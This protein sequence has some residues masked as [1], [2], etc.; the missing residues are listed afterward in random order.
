[1]I[2]LENLSK[3]LLF[4]HLISTIVLIGSISLN[5]IIILAGYWR[6]KFFKKNLEK[7]CVKTSFWTYAI[8]CIFGAL[9]YPT[10]RVRIRYEYFDKT[11]PWA[12]GLFEVKEHWSTIGFTLFM[13]YYFLREKFDPE[14]EK[15]NLFFYTL[16]CC[17]L[18]III[19]YSAS[20]GYY[21]TT[22]KGIWKMRKS[23]VIYIV[24]SIFVCI[25]SLSYCSTIW[26]HLNVPTYYPLEHTWKMIQHEG[27]PS[28]R[29]YGMTAFAFLSSTIVSSCIYVILK[30]SKLK[31]ES[32]TP[33]VTKLIGVISTSLIV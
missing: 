31:E 22:L 21:L 12:T 16:M 2:F 30:F 24:S 10:F 11:L 33:Y 4:L 29:W 8:V 32:L 15:E 3:L 18:F 17:I 6:G 13:A 5:L 1:M 26:F 7:L 28:Q 25:F 9:A 14:I 27:I 19:W 23:D 20:I